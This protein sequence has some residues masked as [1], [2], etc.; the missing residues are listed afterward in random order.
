MNR[1]IGILIVAIMTSNAAA[2]VE[3]T[4]YRDPSEG[5]FTIDVPAGWEVIGGLKRRSINQPHPLLGILSPDHLTKIVFGDPEAIA[6][7]ELAGTMIGL[8]F[9]EGQQYT[10]RG[11]PEIIKNYRTG[12]DRSAELA[13]RELQQDQCTNVKVVAQQA[14]PKLDRSLPTPPGAEHRDTAGETYLTC[15]RQNILYAAYAFSETAG[16]YYYQG[17]QLIA[18][19]WTD[20]TS[21]V[22]LT[23]QGLGGQAM[24]VASH[25]LNSMQWNPAWWQQQFHA[26]VA[27]SNVMY[28][29]AV[30]TVANQSASWDRTIRGVEQYTN[31]QTGKLVEVPATGATA[32]AQNG[33]GDI[34][35]LVGTNT[36]PAGYTLL[37]KPPPQKPR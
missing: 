7:G 32:F 36:P 18:G 33:A 30:K 3:W 35:S 37:T 28:A 12:T 19:V 1:F 14:I 31:P 21:V 11:E 29:Q 10:P 22:L 34:I 8:G 23:P 24:A 5:A 16:D 13:Q 20:D 27:Q 26:A 17:N 9:H 6:F 25:M 2:A 4:K 15:V